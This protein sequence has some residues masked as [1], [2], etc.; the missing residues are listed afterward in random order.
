[1]NDDVNWNST[2][3]AKCNWKRTRVRFE[4]GDWK[5]KKREQCSFSSQDF[6][7]RL[8]VR[9]LVIFGIPISDNSDAVCVAV[10]RLVSPISQIQLLRNLSPTT[11]SRIMMFRVVVVALIAVSVSTLSLNCEPSLFDVEVLLS[12]TA[13]YRQT[14]WPRRYAWLPSPLLA[15]SRDLRFRWT[16]TQRCE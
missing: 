3:G 5:F 4:R 1:M 13:T 2:C 6:G 7:F 14:N 16:W 10:Q 9:W 12:A 15:C 11:Q 8:S